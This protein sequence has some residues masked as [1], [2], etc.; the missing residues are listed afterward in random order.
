MR[1]VHFRTAIFR[2]ISRAQSRERQ[3]LRPYRPSAEGRRDICLPDRLKERQN[4][5]SNRNGNF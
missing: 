3:T 1:S 5:Y 4:N 2:D